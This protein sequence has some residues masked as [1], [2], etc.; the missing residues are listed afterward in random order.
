MTAETVFRKARRMKSLAA[1]LASSYRCE[2]A[3]NATVLSNLITPELPEFQILATAPPLGSGGYPFS[4]RSTE[5][6]FAF[7]VRAG[8]VLPSGHVCLI[9]LRPKEA[10]AQPS[11]LS[12]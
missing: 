2:P 3:E 12:A 9:P 4:A 11:L 5:L 8:A 1:T 6:L 10:L 7:K